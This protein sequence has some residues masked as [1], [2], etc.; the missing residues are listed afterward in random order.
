M[1][2]KS[3]VGTCVIITCMIAVTTFSYSNTALAQAGATAEPVEI[4]SLSSSRSSYDFELTWISAY[5][6]DS[7]GDDLSDVVEATFRLTNTSSY[8]YEYVLLKACGELQ[9]Y[10]AD[11]GC[12]STVPNCPDPAGDCWLDAYHTLFPQC[13]YI[14]LMCVNPEA[15]ID[16]Y[17]AV[18]LTGAFGRPYPYLFYQQHFEPYESVDFTITFRGSLNLVHTA[19]ATEVSLA[20][21]D[22]DC[23]GVLDELDNC[24]DDYNPFQIDDDGDWVGQVCDCDDLDITVSPRWTE[25]YSWSACGDGKDNDCDGLTDMEDDGCIRTQL[26]MVDAYYKGELICK[27]YK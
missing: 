6:S 17:Q 27:N 4:M 3:I 21:R 22:K 9:R 25:H 12:P 16:P 20:F 13:S 7:N 26:D 24:P 5:G 19:F 14:W 8:C 23:D 15:A 10:I 2:M 11:L 18:T 1:K